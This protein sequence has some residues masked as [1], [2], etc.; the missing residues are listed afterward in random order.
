MSSEDERDPAGADASATSDVDAPRATSVR[1]ALSTRATAGVIALA[2]ALTVA[3]W[4]HATPARWL[5]AATIAFILSLPRARALALALARRVAAATPGRLRGWL[6]P[7]AA[8][9]LLLALLFSELI[10]GLPPASRDHAIHFLQVDILARD[11][12][13]AGHLGGWTDRVGNGHALGDT[14]PL[15]GHVWMAALHLV[16]A[17][18]LSLRTSYAWGQLMMWIVAAGAVGWLAGGLAEELLPKTGTTKEENEGAVPPARGVGVTAGVTAAA[19]WLLDGG[20]S[21]EGGWHYMMFHGVW[22]QLLSTAL[23][24]LG[25]ALA[26]WTARRPS[27]RR[28]AL[29]ALALAGG[30]LAHPF[31]L[32]TVTTS[33]A[34]GVLVLA[35]SP[36][37]PRGAL[38]TWLLSHS[39]ALAL[40]L[41]WLVTFLGGGEDM[42]RSPVPWETWDAL[43]SE[44]VAGELFSE[45]R[46]WIGPL[47]LIGGAVAILR[48]GARGRPAPR[49]WLILLCLIALLAQGSR[50]AITGLE[51]DL[52]VPAL[53]NLQFIRYAI[54][55]KPLWY[56]LAGVGAVALV[57]GV[58]EL[59]RARSVRAPSSAPGVTLAQRALLCLFLGPLALGALD[60]AARLAARPVGAVDTL[61]R[62][63]HGEDAQALVSLLA[64]ERAQLGSSA[65][66]HDPTTTAPMTVAYLRR[67]MGGG[68]YPILVLAEQRARV[69]LDGHIP[70]VNTAHR[71]QHRRPE[72]LRGLGVTHVI[73][74]HPLTKHEAELADALEPVGRFGPYTLARVKPAPT[75]APANAREDPASLL[76]GLARWPAT[77]GQ[78]ELLD[79]PSRRPGAQR[80]EFAI[81]GIDARKPMVLDLLIAP[82]HK[83]RARLLAADGSADGATELVLK[84]RA[85]LAGGVTGMRAL[86]PRDGRLELRFESSR[87]ERVCGL[88]SRAALALCLLALLFGRPLPLRARVRAPAW[89][90][91]ARWIAL[92]VVA[93]LI[94]SA[95]FALAR[96][97]QATLERTWTDP[98]Q[99]PVPA[100][101]DQPARFIRD[102]SRAGRYRVTRDPSDICDALVGRDSRRGCSAAEQRPRV[103]QLY[104]DPYLYRCVELTVPA[105]G[106]AAVEFGGLEDAHELRG[107]VAKDTGD[108]DNGKRLRWTVSGRERQPIAI[109]TRTHHLTARPSRGAVTVEF[110]NDAPRD[111]TVCVA[112]AEVEVERADARAP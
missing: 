50:D 30:L 59:A 32:L 76:P 97:Q 37:R 5:S 64:A 62:S 33:A 102:L 51:L 87:R 58:A 24:T 96:R 111:L 34:L 78:V 22:P 73:H 100:R 60:G 77:S 39:L 57:R 10:L 15:L 46:A 43:A 1:A 9:A 80:Y 82:H 53:K 92:A 29:T 91:G 21:R 48:P 16:S 88:I 49:A 36:A 69:V 11:L 28:V 52:I 40:A 107:L 54:A 27:P 94:A 31:G 17:G 20:A 95:A 35:L 105:R 25:I 112:A 56:A 74:D 3:L 85:L 26:W 79:G 101:E 38:R 93:A 70:S 65:E 18:A 19:L 4:S 8:L 72:L 71:V 75:D 44:L 89:S 67:G 61:E 98:D 45:Q 84:R 23:W 81:T 110:T 90:E 103:G 14:Y 7:I 86:V 108:G 42:G 6:W 12:L 68:T 104:D 2:L 66:Q 55:L 109:G 99:F 63:R 47:A 83:W 41:A 13:P 106:R